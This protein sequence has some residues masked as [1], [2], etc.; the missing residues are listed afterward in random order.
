M[1]GKEKAGALRELTGFDRNTTP[2]KSA[3]QYE[4]DHLNNA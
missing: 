2:S 4:R 1:T 3:F